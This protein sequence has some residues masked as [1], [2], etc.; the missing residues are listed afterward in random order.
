MIKAVNLLQV[1]MIP[2]RICTEMTRCLYASYIQD[3][4]AVDIIEIWFICV[5]ICTFG[6]ERRI[7]PHGQ[8]ALFGCDMQWLCWRNL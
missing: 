4:E 3:L 2:Y 5:L 1:N 7:S 6:D 8:D